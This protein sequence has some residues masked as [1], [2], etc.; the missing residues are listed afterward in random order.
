MIKAV[1]F[2]MD[3]L[4]F[5][6]E[7]AY[8]VVQGAMSKKRGKTFTN[9]IKRTLMGKRAVEV[10]ELL[11]K[12][13]GKN[14]KIEDLLLEQDEELTRAYKNSV[15]KLEGL[16]DIIE[17][18]D[19]NNIRKCIGTSSRRFLVDV[20]LKKYDLVGAFEFVV[21]GDIV[22]KGKPDPEI[23]DRCIAQLDILA[24]ECIVLEDSLNGVKAAISAG[25]YTCAIPS[26]YTQN[27][28]F[29]VSTVVCES[30]RDPIIKNFILK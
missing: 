24:T 5:D 30:L 23:Y 9:E 27:E 25:C 6:T 7:S 17:F 3:G 8:S 26:E 28:D 1:I 15:G 18:L 14:E 2:D 22:A 21:S 10:M 16:D 29:S 11:N 20:L 19:Q 4:M 12:F 13:W